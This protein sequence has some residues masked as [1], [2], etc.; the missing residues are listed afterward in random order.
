VKNCASYYQNI[1]VL[2]VEKIVTDVTY[3]TNLKTNFKTK[4]SIRS[5]YF[6]LKLQKKLS[7]QFPNSG[8]GA[9][10]VKSPPLDDLVYKSSY[11]RVK[12]TAFKRLRIEVKSLG[13]LGVQA[14]ST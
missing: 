10:R 2:L 13:L 11:L 3:I 1:G 5:K 12:A 4:Y 14:K 9:L 6:E 7:K 8:G